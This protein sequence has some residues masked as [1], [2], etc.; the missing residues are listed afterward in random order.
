MTRWWVVP[1]LVF[2]IAGCTRPVDNP[3]ARPQAPIGPITPGQVADL[4]SPDIFDKDGNLFATVEPQRCAGVA[5]EV[6]PPF[7]SDHDPEAE[8]GGHWATAVGGV[9]A[10]VEEMVAVY[11]SDF[12]AAG[13]VDRARATVEEC[14]GTAVTVTTMLGRTYTFDVQPS[15]QPGPN[16]SVLWSLRAPEWNCDNLFVAAHNAAIEITSCGTAGGIDTATAA[17]EARQRIE[18]LAD[19]TA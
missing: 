15:A 6:D 3:Q 19:N 9:D 14:A 17:E 11:P 12:S 1:V 16:G 2:A 8:D 18:L 13:A 5:R 4:L 10:V 7:I